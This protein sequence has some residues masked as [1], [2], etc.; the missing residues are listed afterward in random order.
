MHGMTRVINSTKFSGAAN[1]IRRF[2]ADAL[3]RQGCGRDSRFRPERRLRCDLR[4]ERVGFSLDALVNIATALGCRV[5][6]DLEAA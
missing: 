1:P 2:Q 4:S 5:R 3:D 6:F